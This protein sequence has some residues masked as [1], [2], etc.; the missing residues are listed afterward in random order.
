[1]E[2][3]LKREQRQDDGAYYKPFG[4]D[5]NVPVKEFMHSIAFYKGA[6]LCSAYRKNTGCFAPGARGVLCS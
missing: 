6:H 2:L 3:R 5:C 1:M 4:D